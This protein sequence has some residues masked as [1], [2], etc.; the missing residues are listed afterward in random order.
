MMSRPSLPRFVSCDECRSSQACSL[1]PSNASQSATGATTVVPP[2]W[3]VAWIGCAA[4]AQWAVTKRRCLGVES[5][6][7]ACRI[8]DFDHFEFVAL[9]VAFAGL[10]PL[11]CCVLLYEATRNR[12]QVERDPWLRAEGREVA[13]SRD[14]ALRNRL[15]LAA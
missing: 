15:V 7:F 5:V 1:Q 6:E 13:P 11:L 14:R 10:G 8:V 12:A 2:Q 3:M 9:Q 4:A